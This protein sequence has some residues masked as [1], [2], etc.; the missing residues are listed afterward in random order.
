[1]RSA[2]RGTQALACLMVAMLAGVAQAAKPDKTAVPAVQPG[3][4][5][6]VFL[7]HSIVGAKANTLIYE[8][9]S[10]QPKVV[11]IIP[12]N[13][14][15]VVSVAPGD[16]VF[17]IGNLPTCDFLQTSLLPDKRYY[18]VVVSRWPDGFTLR[19]VRNG[20]AR[21]G[22]YSF[23]SG[24]FPDLLKYTTLA[25]RAPDSYVQSELK[26]AETYYPGKWQQWQSKTGEQKFILTLRPADGES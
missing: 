17:M 21:P 20:E 3:Q 11:G 1:M 8:T 18:A 26:N 5:Q 6:I 25:G 19:P 16:H 13:R 4:A 12:N 24:E 14:K 22:E 10:G 2:R 23:K 7:R 9:T 15:L